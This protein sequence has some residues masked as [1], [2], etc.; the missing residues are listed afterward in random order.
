MKAIIKVDVP[1]WQIGQ[2]VSVYFP[3]TM[4][5]HGKCEADILR[6]EDCVEWCGDQYADAARC[7]LLHRP[8]ERSDYCS[9]AEARS[10]C[11]EPG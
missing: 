8:R 4:W 1:E 2:N 9:L 10:E 6:C 5:I 7:G 11:N 3:D